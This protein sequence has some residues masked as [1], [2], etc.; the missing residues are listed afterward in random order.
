M[1]VNPDQV[2]HI[3]AVASDDDPEVKLQNLEREVDQ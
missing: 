2:D 1:A 3:V